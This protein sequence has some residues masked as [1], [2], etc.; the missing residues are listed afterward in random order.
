MKIYRNYDGN[1]SAFGDVSVSASAPNPDNL[2]AFAAQRSTDGALTIMVVNKYLSGNTPAVIN[3]ANFAGGAAAQV[4]Q[5]TAANTINRLA[6][7]PLSG[8]SLNVTLPAQSVTLFVLAQSKVN[9]APLASLSAAPTSGAAPLTVMFNGSA[10]S[11]PDGTI[12]AYSWDFG[13]GAGA[14]SSTTSHVYSTAGTYMARL[15]VTDNQG[16]SNSKTVNIQVSPNAPTVPAAPG[17][18]SAA[19]VSRTQINLAWTDN[20]SNENGFKV[21]RCTGA[22]CSNF[23]QIA[24]VAA[25]AASYANSGLKRNTTYR[26]RIRAYNSA[27]NSAYSNVISART[28]R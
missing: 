23:K 7:A 28:L 19:A 26:Y 2:S 5:L 20:S 12:A 17:G 1:Q 13:D 3:L 27:G 15:T 21:E 16:A 24:T 18:L 25:D 22:T 4:W 9:Q 8:A 6:D 11:D 14:S 10:S